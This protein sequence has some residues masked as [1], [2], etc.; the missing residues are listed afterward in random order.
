MYASVSVFAKVYAVISVVICVDMCVVVLCRL[1]ILKIIL[2]LNTSG[3]KIGLL[4]LL[5]IKMLPQQILIV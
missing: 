2:K 5:I 1:C 4:L 3:V